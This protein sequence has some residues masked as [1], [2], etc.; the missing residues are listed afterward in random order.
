MTEAERRVVALALALSSS[1]PKEPHKYRTETRVPWGLMK[2]LR[3]ALADA[4]Y[5][6]EAAQAARVQR[7]RAAGFRK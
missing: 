3:R 4:G 7:E 1:A 6:W 2:D 5:D